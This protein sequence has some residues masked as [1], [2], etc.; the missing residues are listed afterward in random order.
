MGNLQLYFRFQ[1]YHR[2]RNV[3]NVLTSS[4]GDW[5]DVTDIGSLRGPV[6]LQSTLTISGEPADTFLDMSNWQKGIVFVNG[7]NIGRYF[8]SAGPQ[9]TL[10]VPAGLMKMGDNTV[11]YTY[12]NNF[13]I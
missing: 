1:S 5:K 9:Q 2:L 4:L 10:Y 6:L 11:S 12:S 3:K 13:Q 7:F 8:S